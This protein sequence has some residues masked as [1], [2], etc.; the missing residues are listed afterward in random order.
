VIEKSADSPAPIPCEAP[1]IT[2][3]LCGP[4]MM[5]LQVKRVKGFDRDNLP[6]SS[7]QVDL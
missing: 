3:T 7:E 4:F 1:V 2:A 5:A 6:A